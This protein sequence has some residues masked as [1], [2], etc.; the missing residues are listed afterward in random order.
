MISASIPSPDPVW[1]QFQLGPLTIHTYA[2]CLLA[3]IAA[4]AWI[5]DRRLRAARPPG[6]RSTSP[7]GPC[8]S[9][10]WAPGSTTCSPT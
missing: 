10:S 9:A 7:C 3:G 1:S 2:L 5:T 6:W 8:R 4:A